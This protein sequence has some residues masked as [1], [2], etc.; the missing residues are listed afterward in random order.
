M[1]LKNWMMGFIITKRF[2]FDI[3]LMSN[4]VC[5]FR[6]GGNLFI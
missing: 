1:N 3:L 5:H 2:D 6:E 4:F